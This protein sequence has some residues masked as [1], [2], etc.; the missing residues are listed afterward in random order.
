MKTTE[1]QELKAKLNAE[2]DTILDQLQLLKVEKR[3]IARQLA[4]VETLLGDSAATQYPE[5]KPDAL[6]LHEEAPA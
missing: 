1:L 2:L 4:A 3:Q 5:H 6:K